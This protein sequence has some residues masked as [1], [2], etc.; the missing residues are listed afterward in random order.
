MHLHNLNI[1]YHLKLSPPFYGSDSSWVVQAFK[2]QTLTCS[3]LPTQEGW[4]QEN[5]MIFDGVKLHLLSRSAESFAVPWI[6]LVSC[7][8]SRLEPSHHYLHHKAVTNCSSIICLCTP[9]SLCGCGW[10]QHSQK[11][12]HQLW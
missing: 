4:G 12:D 1:G 6:V 10:R 7:R 5:S 8:W 11:S 9:T 2:V 3:K